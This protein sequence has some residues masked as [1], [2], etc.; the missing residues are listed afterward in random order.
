MN[1]VP[2][3]SLINLSVPNK[4]SVDMLQQIYKGIYAA[5]KDYDLQITGGD[6]TASYATLAITVT[7]AG[8]VHKNN[9]AYRSGAIQE[10]LICISGD[11][12]SATAGLRILMRE[13]QF[14]EEQEN[15]EQQSFQPD[16]DEYE[17][18]VK[19]QLLPLARRDVVQQLGEHEIIPHAMIDITQGL[20]SELKQMT[21]ASGCGAQIYQSSLPIALETRAVAD[22][23]KEDVDKYALYGGE[24]LELMFT[25]PEEAVNN[26]S[27]EFKG[28]NVIG[29]IVGSEQGM[30]MHTAEGDL[31]QFNKN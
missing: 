19:R 31:V 23:M 10:D 18:V 9:I 28:F 17:Y 4:L 22:E 7:A 25:I 8:T 16:L 24:D 12:G 5:G 2:E 21:K 30:T 1:G 14:W 26:L 6:L 13:K 27:D 3:T 20:V 11:L 29:K 15:N